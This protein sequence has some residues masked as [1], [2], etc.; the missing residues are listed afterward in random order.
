MANV[1]IEKF[2]QVNR[3]LQRVG[4]NEL[5]FEEIS[6]T[7]QKVIE[8]QFI[9]LNQEGEIVISQ[10]GSLKNVFCVEDL[11][12]SEVK[13]Y[14]VS[15]LSNEENLSADKL[16]GVVSAQNIY[17]NLIPVIQWDRI[18]KDGYSSYS[19]GQKLGHLIL[20]RENQSFDEN[21][22]IVVEYLASLVGAK[23]SALNKAKKEEDERELNLVKLAVETL[24]YSEITAIYNILK[25]LENQEGLLVA[26]KIADE[27]GITRSVIVNALRKLESAGVVE[28]R[29][30]GAKGT[31][32]KVINRYL[33]EEIEKIG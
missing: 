4:T 10:M 14:C 26:S 27:V 11:L 22:L 25:N 18:D 21:D 2:R 29:S 19:M 7:I 17:C 12:K 13:E 1:L 9:L 23:M 15:L 32:I 3:L 20:L 8:A 16:T 6:E 5:T 31:Y 30:L 33:V 24:S 28:S